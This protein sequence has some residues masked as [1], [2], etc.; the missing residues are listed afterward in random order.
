MN[1][2]VDQRDNLESTEYS[3][4]KYKNALDIFDEKENNKIQKNLKSEEQFYKLKNKEIG[5]YEI[6]LEKEKEDKEDVKKFNSFKNIKNLFSFKNSN[7][8]HFK[9]EIKNR[10]NKSFNIKSNSSK[11]I[12][13][14]LLNKKKL[15]KNSKL[16]NNEES[17]SLENQTK[18]KKKI[19]LVEGTRKYN[20]NIKFK[21]NK[22]KKSKN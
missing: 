9:P 22:I 2:V 3:K 17:K 4:K 7:K 16:P 19:Y 21:N 11:I 14:N 8:N 20:N 15:I 18:K 12:L 1:S 5:L 6:A 13:K 10:N